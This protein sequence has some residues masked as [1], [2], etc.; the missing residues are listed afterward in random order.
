M[1]GGTAPAIDANACAAAV[2]A[3]V[4]LA[5]VAMAP[6][7]RDAVLASF[8]AIAAAASLVE[9]FPLPDGAEYAPVF[10]P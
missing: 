8:A 6:E 10:H 5:G 3:A 4:L 2:D 1:T 7:W 9:G